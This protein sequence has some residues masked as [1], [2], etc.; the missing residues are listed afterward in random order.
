MSRI[1]DLPEL[2]TVAE[3]AEVLH[4]SDET[5]H[6]W[7][8]LGRLDFADVLGNKRLFKADIM[9]LASRRRGRLVSTEPAAEEAP[10]SARG[11]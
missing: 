3:A 1:D 4:V 2:M 7:C 10:A 8:R 11:G 6:R 9:L 5:I